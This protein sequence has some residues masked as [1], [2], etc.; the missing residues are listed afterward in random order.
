MC[1]DALCSLLG[2]K[3][4]QDKSRFYFSP[5]VAVDERANLCDISGF[6]LLP[7]VRT[8]V[9]HLLGTYVAILCNWLIL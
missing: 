8:Y 1:L 4:S 3:V 9:I 6:D 7:L 5:N 2:Q